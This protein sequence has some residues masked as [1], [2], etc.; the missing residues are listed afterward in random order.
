MNGHIYTWNGAAW[1][2]VGQIVGPKGD[3]GEQGPIG[4][5]GPK[6]DTGPM[7]PGADLDLSAVTQNIVPAT[8]LTFDLGS[9]DKPWRDVYI[10]PNTLY[11]NG[12]PVLSD[13]NDTMTFSTDTNQN[14]RL[15][16]TGTGNLELFA[17]AA[18]G[19][20]VQIKSTM[21]IASGKKILDSAGVEVEFGDNINMGGNKIT[22]VANPVGNTDVV[23]KGY[24][25]S[26][27]VMLAGDQTIGGV[28]TFMTDVTITGNLSVTG[29]TTTR[30]SETIQIEDNIIE[31]NS[32]VT[33]G[34]PTENS[35]FAVRRGDLG[36]VRFIW[37]E[38]NDRFT[39]VDGN[40]N[41]LNL[42]TTGNITAST[43][44][45]SIQSATKLATARNI[46]GVAFDG[47]QNISFGSDAVAEGVANL[48]HT[49]VRAR[50]AISVSGDL[51]YNSTSGVIS[52][53]APSY[54]AV[55]TTGE[56]ADLLNK[57][58][59]FSGDYNDLTNKPNVGDALPSQAGNAGKYLKTDGTSV[60][61]S[62]AIGGEDP[63][64]PL[65]G[66]AFDG[67]QAPPV[68][69]YVGP[70]G[71]TGET[72]PEGPQGPAGPAG[73]TDFNSLTNKPTL[74]TLLPDQTGNEGKVLSTDG[75]NATWTTP[76]GGNASVDEKTLM[77]YS[78]IF[79]G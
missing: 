47:T 11:M 65:D 41:G 56:Y 21:A 58:A 5:Q 63:T 66:G 10:G 31:L 48:Y 29:T 74:N 22:N 70:K 53:T 20:Q 24:M 34:E 15:Q 2:D 16:T 25:A 45:G 42:Y 17:D 27:V 7:G 64:T 67:V 54:A 72:G 49:P 46:N 69:E 23:T 8:A 26:N 14:L 76:S 30:L 79:G 62:E 77:L 73:T 28:K 19:G 44:T 40:G 37:D 75:A 36:V 71:D 3:Q 33:T 68:T 78:L 39:M 43:Y 50:A 61:W 32:N 55:A 51:S 9:P 60:S 18:T 4:P 1:V 59:I 57:P 38:T 13:V 6:G 35:G 52:Y 12:K